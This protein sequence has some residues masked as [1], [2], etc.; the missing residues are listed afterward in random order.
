LM[1]AVATRG[2]PRF[3]CRNRRNPEMTTL[4]A[5]IRRW[6]MRSPSRPPIWLP[7]STPSPWVSATVAARPSL[8]P[9]TRWKNTTRYVAQVNQNSAPR[10]LEVIA[11]TAERSPRMSA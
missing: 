7:M 1:S 2:N 5:T 10:K 9:K 4:P 8:S 3:V 6:P 11:A